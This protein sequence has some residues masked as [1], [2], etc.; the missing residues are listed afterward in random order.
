MY[1]Y[2]YAR[3]YI[4]IIKEII[5]RKPTEVMASRVRDA[6]PYPQNLPLGVSLTMLSVYDHNLRCS[7]SL[8]LVSLCKS[9]KEVSYV[10]I[11]YLDTKKPV[12]LVS[13][14]GFLVQTLNNKV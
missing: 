5:I 14:C 3:R 10:E 13:Y 12:F 1:I 4:S 7:G 6:P 2:T 11:R 9:L 8:I